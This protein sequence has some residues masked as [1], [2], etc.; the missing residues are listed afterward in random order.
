MK[1]TFLSVALIAA[2]CSVTFTS[3]KK[4]SEVQPEEEV[5]IQDDNDGSAES[6]DIATMTE[7]ALLQSNSGRVEGNGLCGVTVQHSINV[8]EAGRTD[9]V[10]VQSGRATIDFG[11][12]KT[13]DDNKV[14]KGKII[15]DYVNLNRATNASRTIS[16]NGYSVNGVTVT[17]SKTIKFSSATSAV[18]AAELTFTKDGKSFTWNTDRT[19]TL[20]IN[21][22]TVTITG[23]TSG[24]TREGIGFSSYISKGL[25]F[26]TNCAN[27]RMP[28]SG[29]IYVTPAK[30]EKQRVIDF[31]SGDCDRKYTVTLEDMLK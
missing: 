4:D 19:R 20:D 12:G 24:T 13:C 1:K 29:T 28:V 26:K 15:I 22:G 5:V 17:G 23:S 11:T 21:A 10:I 25:V 31:G 6:E 9:A 8:M 16:F 27:G 18:I 3:C 2:M 14:R 30:A 7:D